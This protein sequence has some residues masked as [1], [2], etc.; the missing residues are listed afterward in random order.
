[1]MKMVVALILALVASTA[2]AQNCPANSSRTSSGTCQCNAGYV[3]QG[4]QCVR[5]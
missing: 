2:V 3:A 1:M 5:Q 4:G